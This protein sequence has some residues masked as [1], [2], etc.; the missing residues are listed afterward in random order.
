[1]TESEI[2]ANVRAKIREVEEAKAPPNDIK[3]EDVPAKYTEIIKTEVGIWKSERHGAFANWWWRPDYNA[4]Q[5]LH[6]PIADQLR[7]TVITVAGQLAKEER[8]SPESAR[9]ALERA[10]ELELGASLYPE[11][12][13]SAYLAKWLEDKE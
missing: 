3:L 5:G 1:M 9:Q 13:P 7:V 4:K 11:E 6:M 2:K 8:C 10:L 12:G